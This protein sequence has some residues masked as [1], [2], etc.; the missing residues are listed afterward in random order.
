MKFKE[1][2]KRIPTKI[3]EDIIKLIKNLLIMIS[4]PVTIVVTALFTYIIYLCV[5]GVYGITLGIW[6]MYQVLF[7]SDNH[8]WDGSNWVDK[9]GNVYVNK[10]NKKNI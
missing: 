6:L 2:I 7:K 5:G 8:R 4:N 9:D 1:R 3:K 10:K